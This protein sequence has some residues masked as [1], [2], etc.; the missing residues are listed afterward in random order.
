MEKVPFCCH[1][2]LH[3]LCAQRS[4]SDN[5]VHVNA[6]K[7]L[8]ETKVALRVQ[9]LQASAQERHEITIDHLTEKL[10]NAGMRRWL[11]GLGHL[12]DPEMAGHSVMTRQHTGRWP[13]HSRIGGT[14][15]WLP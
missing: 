7:L 14:G 2:E 4:H 1:P 9:E 5:M 6:S 15:L 11:V 12:L 8:A 3:P 10:A 13:S